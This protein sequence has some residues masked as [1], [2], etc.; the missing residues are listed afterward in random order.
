MRRRIK[1]LDKFSEIIRHQ[2]HLM[3]NFR[4]VESKNGFFFPSSPVLLDDYQGQHELRRLAWHIQ[5]ELCEAAE[6]LDRSFGT[7]NEEVNKELIDAL[8]FVAEFMLTLG[9]WP[10]DLPPER[11]VPHADALL[12]GVAANLFQAMIDL[13]LAINLLKNKP[14]KQTARPVSADVFKERWA[15]FIRSFV[16]TCY[17][18]GMTDDDIQST[19]LGKAAEN[20]VR[21]NTGV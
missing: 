20:Q 21:I 1:V 14:W 9:Y 17:A 16:R 2:A 18:C 11:T 3:E 10:S 5:E 13:G 19:Y 6:A 7:G 15:K 4:A 12:D 8:H